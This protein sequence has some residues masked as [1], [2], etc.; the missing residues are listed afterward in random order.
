MELAKQRNRV[1]GLGPTLRRVCAVGVALLVVAAGCA[2]LAAQDKPAAAAKPV[3]VL[4][5]TGFWRMH[6][7]LRPPVVQS[8]DGTKTVLFGQKWLDE[9]TAAAPAG[10]TDPE[11]D[12]SGWVRAVAVRASRTPYLSR[13]CLRGRFEVT[14]PARV[15]GLALTVAYYGG[16]IVYVN[17]REVAR[18][19]LKPGAAGQEILAEGYPEEAFLTPDG[20]LITRRT[21]RSAQ[22]AERLALR[23]RLLADLPISPKL[24]RKGVNVVAVELVR[25]PYPRILEEK[26]MPDRR[27]KPQYFF[28]FNT[29]EIRRVQLTAAKADGLVPNATR[30]EGLQVWNSD[31]M[32]STFDLDFGDRC[33]KVRAVRIVGP[34]NGSFSG[35]F[36]V[37]STRPIRGLKVTAGALKSRGATIPASTLSLRYALPWDREQLVIPYS[38]QQPPYPR[39][40]SLLSALAESAPGEVAVRQKGGPRRR[41]DLKTPNQP[42]PVYGAVMPVWLTVSIPAGA[43]PGK[44]AGRVRVEAR[45][46]KPITVPVE[47]T[48]VDWT[49]PDTKDYK[50]W[51]E[52]IES[53]DT[54]A[55]EYGLQLWSEKHWKMIEQAM[56][57]A[58]RTGSR[59][60]HVPLIAQ[61]NLGHE[62]TMVRWIRKGQ[63]KYGYDF[64]ILDRYLAAA[65]KHMG[66]P[67]LVVFWVWDIYLIEKE[68]YKGRDHLILE[69]AI[70]ARS[71][72]RG[73]GPMVTAVDPSSGKTETVTLPP[74][75]DPSSKAL[76][77][78]VMAGVRERMKARG[79]EKAMML[80]IM[81]DTIPTKAEMEFFAD[82][83]PGVPW[84]LHAH[85]GPRFGRPV[86]GV[87]PLG[88][89]A[90]VWGVQ[91]AADKSLHGWKG[92]DLLAYYDRERSLNSHTPSLWGHLAEM[93]ITGSQRG[94]GRLGADYWRPIRDDKGHRIGYVWGRYVHSSWRN[95][96]LWSYVLAPGPDGPVASTYFEYFREGVQHCEARIF[97]AQA[98]LDDGLREKLGEDLAGRCQAA[99]D[100][101]QRSMVKSMAHLQFNNIQN[102]PTTSWRSGAELAG[103]MW[104]VGSGW[105]QR[106]EKLYALAGQAAKALGAEK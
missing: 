97:L 57:Y 34:R 59:V 6:H 42:D 39:A 50:T 53:P 70:A 24:L 96:D 38:S 23:E 76:W 26:K 11:F 65:E 66:K 56:K 22:L 31:L 74:H 33:E 88:Y 72:M 83:C 95:L 48:V 27:K 68:K 93:T 85:S 28:H 94:V 45:G 77:G 99:L 3:V 41:G 44:Y 14:D 55:A 8:G 40:V 61:T 35:K 15:K 106:S 91:F 60:L 1:E 100:E 82:L 21:R 92:K 75:K 49:L 10:W 69:K 73:T 78:P 101:R 51:V 5:T 71:A 87:A 102:R 46:E 64:S 32:M 16:A 37:G 81:N 20:K 54:L 63:G 105:Q 67:K 84:A 18:A 25:S 17:G 43:K 13:L 89:K 9:A 36:V 98:L 7:T 86:H 19:N 104:F 2:A 103:Y 90:V 80:G 12:D 29:C 79:L 30:P 52:L 47:L 58:G 4:D 62:Q